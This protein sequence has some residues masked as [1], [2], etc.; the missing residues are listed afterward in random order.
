MVDNLEAF[1]I[2]DEFEISPGN[3]VKG[4][5]V[6]SFLADESV[7]KNKWRVTKEAIKRDIHTY[8][9]TRFSPVGKTMPFFLELNP[10][11][12]EFKDH[13]KSTET[14]SVF[15]TQESARVGDMIA[16]GWD[17]SKQR[18]WQASRIDDLMAQEAIRRGEVLYVSPG[19]RSLEEHIDE[20]GIAVVTRFLGQHIA[21]VDDP[22]YG[23]EKAK[24]VGTCDSDTQSCIDYFKD[25][26]ASHKEE[27]IK[28]GRCTTTG[29]IVLEVTDL[30]SLSASD[31]QAAIIQFEK[32]A[33]DSSSVTSLKKSSTSVNHTMTMSEEQLQQK[34]QE[35]NKKA[36]D[37]EKKEKEF[38]DAKK[39][40]EDPKDKDEKKAQTVSPDSDGTCPDGWTKGEDGMCHLQSKEQSD[41]SAK[42][43]S[44][45]SEVK[46]LQATIDSKIKRPVAEKIASVQVELG[47]VTQN[48]YEASVDKLMSKPLEELET[49]SRDYVAINERNY[50]SEDAS[51]EP[52]YTYDDKSASSSK[53]EGQEVLARIRVRM[54][55]Q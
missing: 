22:A 35:L 44:I 3:I 40:S 13:P 36:S 48:D 26:Q 29:K 45:Q 30:N 39:A 37:L 47:T 53:T 1:E 8:L 15:I 52:R 41:N 25:I 49:L 33:S 16:V 51:F 43:A 54:G 17:E 14:E 10:T 18:A 50:S 5:F 4:F 42:V 24:I 28:I 34:E 32:N 7:N 46:D 12:K 11:K 19:L 21:G 55:S 20:N 2:L 23:I 27:K 38:K 6:K 31:L 9:D